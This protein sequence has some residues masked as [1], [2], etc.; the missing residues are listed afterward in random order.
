MTGVVLHDVLAAKVRLGPLPLAPVRPQMRRVLDL[1]LA[2][3]ALAMVPSARALPVT[4]DSPA[5]MTCRYLAALPRMAWTRIGGDWTDAGGLRHG[6][7]A[8]DRVN[9]ERRPTPQR[10]QWDATALVR[11]WADPEVWAGALALRGEDAGRT[12][13]AYLAS[14]ESAD[15]SRQPVLHL[16]W[17]GGRVERL[18]A[19]AD[20]LLVCPQYR[21]VGQEPH[22]NVG[23]GQT[24]I[25]LFQRTVGWAADPPQNARLEL[26]SAHQTGVGLPIGLYG[27]S[28]PGEVAT[29]PEPGL[30]AQYPG[31]KG[32]ERDPQVLLVER[33]EA[34]PQRIEWI[35]KHDHKSVRRASQT[36]EGPGF[37]PLDGTALGV[38]IPKGSHRGMESRIS[39]QTLAGEEPQ[40][41]YFRYHLRFGNDW[42]P[43]LDGGKLPGFAGT[44]GRAGWGGRQVDGTNGWSAR[45]SF[46]MQAP[47]GSNL[48]DLRALGSY[49][50][51]MDSGDRFGEVLGWNLGAGGW[52]LKNRWYSIEQHL[53]LNTP[54]QANGVLRAWVDG[55]LVFERRDLKWRQ[56][57]ELAIEML[58]MNVYHGGRRPAPH[59]MTVF[60]DNLVIARQY[61]GPM[62]KGAG[63]TAPR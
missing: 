57:P 27:A 36:S 38:L 61:I 9:V 47:A 53:R 63:P 1:V 7:Q 8:Y 48:H 49:V 35:A 62:T 20:S 39:M 15:L 54:G 2:L 46:A 4:D 6:A 22:M 44:Y 12:G 10:L 29:S 21:S 56:T 19:T 26:W 18:Q 32:L 3:A 34:S 24:A 60:L 43:E 23:P 5:G 51:H 41:L 50:Y 59:D 14:R 16:S 42:N 31:D 37:Q 28:L 13:T 52:L 17:A 58:W 55:R 40:E 45:G 33:F 25:I 30:S 11:H